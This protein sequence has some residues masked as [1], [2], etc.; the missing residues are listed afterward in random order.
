MSAT[1]TAAHGSARSLTHGLRP[2]IEPAF[3]WILV[4]FISPG[5]QWKRRMITSFQCKHLKL[6]FSSQQCSICSPQ[7]LIYWS[8][9]LNSNIL[10]SLKPFSFGTTEYLE[11]S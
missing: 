4:G 7:I 11:I 2:G 1:Y 8:F 5:P 9:L 10:I 3:L 6:E